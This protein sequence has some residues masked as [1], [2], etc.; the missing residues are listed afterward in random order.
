MGTSFN[1]R[2]L[3][4]KFDYRILLNL[5]TITLSLS[6]FLS[7]V[8]DEDCPVLENPENGAVTITGQE[9]GDTASYVC[10]LGYILDGSNTRTCQASGIWSGV[11]P[12]CNR[13][14]SQ[15]ILKLASVEYNNYMY[16]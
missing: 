4:P 13:K 2:L 7:I 10:N 11:A 3:I 1:S 15:H 5:T 12:T 6:L 14:L 9:P 8:D 16:H